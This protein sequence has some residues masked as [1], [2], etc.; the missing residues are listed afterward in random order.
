MSQA[1][2]PIPATRCRREIEIK[3]SRFITT[4]EP[5]ADA[6][7]AQ[8]FIAR[9]K[10][11]FPDAS[12][13]CWAYLCGPPGSSDR[14]GLSDDG[15]PHGTA[16]KPLLTTLQHSGLG[17]IALVVTRYFGGTKLGKGGL[18]K[19]YTDAAQTALEELPRGEKIAWHLLWLDFSYA[20][21]TPLELQLKNYEAR[22]VDRQFTEQVSLQIKLPKEQIAPLTTALNELS[23]GQIRVRGSETDQQ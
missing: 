21:L 16:G 20:L 1:R 12:H 10:A 3:R 15:E 13:N 4:I 17:D 8:A 7:R 19:A 2:Y 22:V 14:I 9:I 23:S 6:T 11:E 18:V 5:A